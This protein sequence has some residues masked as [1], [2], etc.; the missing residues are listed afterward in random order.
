MRTK[1]LQLF[2]WLYMAIMFFVSAYIYGFVLKANGDNVEHLHASW[3]IWM[4]EIPYKD[5]FQHHNPLTW[6]LSAPI[7]ASMI[8]DFNVFAVINIIG[9]ATLYVIAY[10]QSKIF[11]L[12]Q[13]NKTAALFLAA[14]LVSAYS[15]LWS[16]DYRPDT[17]MFAFFYMGLY[18]L[19][20]YVQK[21]DVNAKSLILSFLFFFISFLFTQKVLM[22]LVVPGI[23][24]IYWLL[25]KKIK[26]SHFLYA[27]ILPLVLLLAFLGYF[28]YHD[29]L[30][31]YWLANYPFNLRI[32][33]IFETQRIIFPPEE[34][35]DF[36]IFLPIAAIASIYLLLKGSMIER[37]FCI[38]FLLETILRL[39]Y[40]SAFLHY[41]IFWLMLA[42]ML[43]VMFFNNFT[44]E[45]Q[46]I[47]IIGI[48]I[49]LLISQWLASIYDYKWTSFNY[50][51]FFTMIGLLLVIRFSDKFIKW[52]NFICVIGI[53]YLLVMSWYSYYK[54]YRTEVK[55]LSTLNGHEIAF[56]V[57]TPCDTALNGY[58]ST[59]NLKAKD[60]GSYWGK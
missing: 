25:I 19:F 44:K 9:L 58:Y 22:H 34:Y 31:I 43:S 3:L 55:K 32:P 12:T 40:F 46:N 38:M 6:Y 53:I 18:E 20:Y 37:I 4:G 2:L 30:Q 49:I 5:F 51:V 60:A 29:A 14:I 35:I 39:F 52:Q 54:T 45:K 17:F 8:D 50:K 36:Y 26:I 42:I 27:C 59:Y 48:F 56:K 21:D 57:L 24:V 23:A 7:V 13:D 28:Y 1:N 11:L 10:Y 16:T 15:L 47:L 41:V 33:E